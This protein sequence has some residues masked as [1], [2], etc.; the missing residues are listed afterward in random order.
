MPKN[1]LDIESRSRSRDSR[2]DRSRDASDRRRNSRSSSGQSRDDSADSDRS[3]YKERLRERERDARNLVT[4]A[5]KREIRKIYN[6]NMPKGRHAYGVQ[7][8]TVNLDIQACSQSDPEWELVQKVG[9][10]H[11]CWT[12][13][14]DINS[15]FF[16]S[17]VGDHIPPTEL[18]AETAKEAFKIWKSKTELTYRG[19]LRWILPSCVQCSKKQAQLVSALKNGR[20]NL[21][22]IT[23]DRHIRR[24]VGGKIPECGVNKLALISSH[25]VSK[26][27]KVWLDDDKIVCHICETTNNARKLYY[28]ADHCPPREFNTTYARKLFKLAGVTVSP[29]APELRP[30]CYSCSSKQ[31]RLTQDSKRLLQIAGEVMIP[32]HK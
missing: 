15:P 14:K 4:T 23:K 28:I 25:K 11:G 17:W 21:K 19:K 26:R 20:I 5:Q 30:Q 22:D 3:R 29:A 8:K 6:R 12:C 9:N 13:P 32:V 7:I 10:D 16:A 31:G 1:G 24:L 27:D 18:D 2:D